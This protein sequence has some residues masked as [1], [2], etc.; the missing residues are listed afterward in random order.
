[1]IVKSGSILRTSFIAVV[2]IF[3]LLLQW[4]S[5]GTSLFLTDDS[6]HYLAGAESLRENLSV[7]DVNG[8][9]FLFW[10]PLFP[11]I[12]SLFDSPQH[13]LVWVHFLTTIVIGL[14]SLKIITLVVIHPFLRGACFVFIVLNVHLLMIA[15]FLWTELIFLALV[16]LFTYQIQ[17][18][19]KSN[20]DMAVLIIFG[21]LMCLQRNAGVFVVCG[22][23]LWLFL[24]SKKQPHRTA[25]ALSVFFFTTI[26]FW[27]WNIFVWLITPHP[28]FNFQEPLFQ[29]FNFN[30]ESLALSL[31]RV[32]VFTDHYPIPIL[33]A[34]CA[35]FIFF[36]RQDIVKDELLQLIYIITVTYLFFIF[37]VLTINLAAFKV[38]FGEADRFI[39]VMMPFLGILFF[40]LIDNLLKAKTTSLAKFA[41]MMAVS[42]WVIYPMA[43]TIK[44]ASSWHNKAVF[45]YPSN[46]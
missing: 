23:T 19:E 43:R 1:M 9:Y 38:D 41:I 18:Q 35:L 22:A 6:N 26:G 2:F 33:V 34:I 40:R 45:Y 32:F 37:F 27:V 17:K 28:H 46:R 42:L 7:R 21:F 12:L 29:H 20:R 16:L 13:A 3:A 14:I 36:M 15:S 24:K 44:N 11:L 31:I 25:Y 8:R 39:S 5:H 10:P 4:F 30:V